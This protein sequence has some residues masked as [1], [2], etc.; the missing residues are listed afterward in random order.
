MN[1]LEFK[2]KIDFSL[3]HDQI[4]LSPI[5]LMCPH[6]PWVDDLHNEHGRIFRS[7]LGREWTTTFPK[8]FNQQASENLPRVNSVEDFRKFIV[9]HIENTLEIHWAISVR[10]ALIEANVVSHRFDLLQ[11]VFNVEEQKGL[12]TSKSWIQFQAT[13]QMRLKNAENLEQS[14]LL[15]P[16]GEISI[17][18]FS[19]ASFLS[20]KLQKGSDAP[21][22]I[23]QICLVSEG[24][25]VTRR[26]PVNQELK[27]DGSITSVVLPAPPLL[28]HLSSPVPAIHPR[29]ILE[30]GRNLDLAPDLLRIESHQATIPQVLCVDLGSSNSR[31]ITYSVP[32]AAV[33]VDSIKSLSESPDKNN[34]KAIH[35]PSEFF[36]QRLGLPSFD[37]ARLS[38]QGEDAICAY[39]VHALTKISQWLGY[40]EARDLQYPHSIIWS[41]PKMDGASLD[42]QR[43]TTRIN[44]EATHLAF[45]RIEFIP[46]HDA[47]S[48]RFNGALVAMAKVGQRKMAERES[49]EA[50]NAEEAS[51]VERNKRDYDAEL[52]KYNSRWISWLWKIGRAHV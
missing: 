50:K 24:V 4:R 37:K 8:E 10:V 18:P 34:G 2:A 44:L 23:D 45:D 36:T 22:L 9:K 33:D 21:I 5:G 35:E 7:E 31:I 42:F 25:E 28:H 13:D 29:L 46:E 39:I 20:I 38:E 47:L 6:L 30:G 15:F 26:A 43:I 11:K 17:K 49:A 14:H 12:P 40:H 1:E 41:F 32:D 3:D 16:P 52:R 19:P 27:Q 48:W 51:T